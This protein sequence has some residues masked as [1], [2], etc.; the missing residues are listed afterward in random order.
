M[1]FIE[2]DNAYKTR[3][4]GHGVKVYACP[5]RRT[6]APQV[7]TN[8]QYGDYSGGGWAW[9][10]IDYAGNSALLWKGRLCLPLSVITD[11]TSQ[12]ILVGEKA[13]CSTAY[14]NGSWLFDEPF[15]LGGSRSNAR[16]GNL[17][18]KDIAGYAYAAEHWGAAH[19]GGA[20][21]LFADGSVRMLAYWTSPEV[22]GALLTP[23]G[24]E[25]V[26]GY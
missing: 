23:D 16:A 20:Q 17:I 12:T 3:D 5:S 26:P 9:G 22:V 15:F 2:E 6:S 18:V 8:D 11:G 19:P 7:V 14:T 21:F 13:M 25:V 1:P 4:W 24:G 10:K